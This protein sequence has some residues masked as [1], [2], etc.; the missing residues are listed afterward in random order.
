[1]GRQDNKK[2]HI[3]ALDPSLTAFG[4]AVL[5]EAGNVVVCGCIQT[6]SSGKK[7]GIRKGDDRCRR[8]SEVNF[9][10]LQLI[11][12]YNVV[13]IVSEQPHGS[14]S[15]VSAVAIGICLGIIQTIADTMDIALEWYG[16]QDCKKHISGKRSVPKD[17]MIELIKEAGYDVFEKYPKYRNEAVADALAVYLL[18]K[19]QSS[20]IRFLKK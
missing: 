20:I 13:L 9:K 7:S 19:S 17:K 11:W 8:I 14:Q 5:D 4:Y 10:L 2:K 16:E 1:M 6:G 12:K 15:A 18:A 3:L